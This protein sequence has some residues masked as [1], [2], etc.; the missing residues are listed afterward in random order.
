MVEE[1]DRDAL[2]EEQ[3]R[4]SHFRFS[5]VGVKLGTELQSVFD[6]GIVYVVRNDR[7]VEFRGQE[8]S[9]FSSALEIAHVKGY[10]WTMIAGPQYWKFDGRTLSELWREGFDED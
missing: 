3:R 8:H 2:D 9:L 5:L 10:M 4:M 1:E 6:D 7:W